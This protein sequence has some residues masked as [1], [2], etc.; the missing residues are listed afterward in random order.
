MLLEKYNE[1]NLLINS[2][3]LEQTTQS[4]VYGYRGELVLV[5][6]GV[7]DNKGHLKPP[8]DIVRGVVLLADDKLKLVVGAID[9][10][11]QIT[12]FMEKYKADINP[13]TRILF[14]VVDIRKPLQFEIDG[15]N[16]VCISM[17]SGVPWNETIDELRLEKSD[18]KGQ[19]PADKILT[20]WKEMQDYRP[21]Y[22]KLSIEEA[23]ACAEDIKREVFGAI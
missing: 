10:I 2:N 16:I 15:I 4:G 20:L 6:G 9:Y 22:P 5:E 13:E 12:T 1:K 21:S 23:L 7:G 18:F 11:Q 8:V 14:Y 17:Q 3:F 19:S